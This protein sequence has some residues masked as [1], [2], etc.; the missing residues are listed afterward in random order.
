MRFCN[1]TFIKINELLDS[2]IGDILYHKNYEYSYMC[3][4][5]PFLILIN[6]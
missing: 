5:Y 6:L 4:K 2:C 3:Q 1:C